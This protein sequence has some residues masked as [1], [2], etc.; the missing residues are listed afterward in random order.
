MQTY[1]TPRTQITKRRLARRGYVNRER[2][3]EIYKSVWVYSVECIDSFAL[4]KEYA[5][6]FAL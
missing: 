4:D 5:P 6:S 1:E 3:F 2:K